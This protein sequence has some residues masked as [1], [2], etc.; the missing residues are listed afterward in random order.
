M[1][2]DMKDETLDALIGALPDSIAP[3]RDLWTGI[4]GQLEVGTP[5]VSH[6]TPRMWRVALAA[7]V[8]MGVTAGATAWWVGQGDPAA[9]EAPLV[10][11]APA[12]SEDTAIWRTEMRAA[13]DALADV[14]TD[15]RDTIDPQVLLVIEENLTII[16]NAMSDIDAALTA[17]PDD[18]ALRA[19]MIDAWRQRITLLERARD[20]SES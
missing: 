16:D 11:E 14:L 4:E 9:V 20:L 8:L 5:E 10:A 19:A 6:S 13:D 3:E 18:P 12:P 2:D 17:S 1:R 7:V 15:R